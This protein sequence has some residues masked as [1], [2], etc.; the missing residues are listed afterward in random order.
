MHVEKN[1]LSAEINVMQ[2]FVTDQD[3]AMDE[4]YGGAENTRT[5]KTCLDVM[6]TRMATVFASL[7][8]LLLHFLLYIYDYLRAS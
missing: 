7:K 1:D 4:L 6:A 3:R 2:A 8:V 5:F